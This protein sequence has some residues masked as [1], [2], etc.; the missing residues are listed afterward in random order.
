[1]GR[2]CTIGTGVGLCFPSFCL[3]VVLM[4]V[5]LI[6]LNWLPSGGAESW[7]SLVLPTVTMAPASSAVLA[8]YTR[9]AVREA[10]DSRYVSAAFARGIPFWRILIHHVLLN[11]A[12]PILTILGLFIGGTV[13]ALPWSRRSSYGRV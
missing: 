12:A 2:V 4:L 9:V 10:L 8:R 5:F 6:H 13:T 3:G 1:M 7:R 11:A